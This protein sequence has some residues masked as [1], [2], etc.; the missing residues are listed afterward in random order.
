[1]RR[2]RLYLI[3]LFVFSSI[4]FVIPDRVS[5][6]VNSEY[7]IEKYDINI[8]VNEDLKILLS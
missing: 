2:N 5:A 4:L 3:L 6:N 1:M 7:T 8:V